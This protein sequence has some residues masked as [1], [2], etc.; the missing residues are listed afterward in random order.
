MAV[1]FALRAGLEDTELR[2]QGKLTVEAGR[3][4]VVGLLVNRS[5]LSDVATVFYRP[6]VDLSPS[7]ATVIGPHCRVGK[8]YFTQLLIN[9][10]A[11]QMSQVA[12]WLPDQW[13][14][15]QAARTPA[16]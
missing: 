5:M 6:R 14:I 12:A 15:R 2:K 8:R 7:I 3:G 9:L 1:I 11:V 10:P 13:K 4:F 16:R